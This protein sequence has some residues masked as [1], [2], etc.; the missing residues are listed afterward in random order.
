MG[1]TAWAEPRKITDIDECYFYHTMDIPGYGTV[2][3]EWDL[4]G[5]ESSYLGDMILTG[6]RVLEI[7]TA[8]GHLC[9]YME[10][11]GAEVVAY[12]ISHRQQWDLIP[13]SGYD[14][15][16][17]LRARREHIHRLNNGFWFAH[18]AFGSNAKMVYGT[19]YDI[20]EDIGLFDVC[21]LGSILLHLRDPFQALHSISKHVRDAVV[22]TDVIPAH[23]ASRLL[24]GGRLIEFLP[25]ADSCS[26]ID[27]WYRLSPEIISEFLKILGFTNII[28]SFHK[29]LFKGREIQLYTIKGFREK[30]DLKSYCVEE[31]GKG[32]IP[33]R[34]EGQRILEEVKLSSISI[35]R[36]TKHLLRRVIGK[37]SR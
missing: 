23:S 30:A 21:T 22:V 37:F 8:S 24:E 36:I 25:D 10:R 19:V 13:Y 12:D 17:Q 5:R 7:G 1:T 18:S 2:T 15:T 14:Y 11:I 6:K 34:G 32:S 4:R 33:D 31:C 27:T 28:V 20:P 29:Q 3:G 16:D 35:P 26:P 9:F